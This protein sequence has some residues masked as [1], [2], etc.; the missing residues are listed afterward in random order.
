M[1]LDLC[2]DM[3][4]KARSP[5]Q[6]KEAA[7]SNHE[8]GSFERRETFLVLYSIPARIYS[9]LEVIEIGWKLNSVNVSRFC[10]C[11]WVSENDSN[12]GTK[13]L[14][15]LVSVVVSVVVSVADVV[16]FTDVV[17]HD[18]T[19]P[20]VDVVVTVV[21]V[22]EVVVMV[23]AV[24]EVVVSVVTVF[25]VEVV[26]T[27]VAVIDVVVTVVAVTLVVVAVTDL[28]RKVTLRVDY[29][30]ETTHES[31]YSVERTK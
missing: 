21:A 14:V 18:V 28:S 6:R 10:K 5:S 15:W 1:S 27:V 23:V 19:V 3:G 25:V 11:F 8:R 17:V 13:M 26:V 12:S 9:S 29:F 4:T 16:V 7:P 24:T 31:F 20:V 2:R 22:T 30:S